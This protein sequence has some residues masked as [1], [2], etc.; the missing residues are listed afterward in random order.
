MTIFE[1]NL[2]T[3]HSVNKEIAANIEHAK[4]PEWAECIRAHNHKP[5]ILVHAQANRVPAY[6]MDNP[7]KRPREYIKDTQFFRENITV[8]IGMGCGYLLHE[9]LKKKDKQHMVLVVEPLHWFM[10]KAFEIYDYSKWILD[11]TLAIAMNEVGAS[12]SIYQIDSAQVVEQYNIFTEPY[13]YLRPH[14]YDKV[15]H[16]VSDQL[17]SMLCNTGTVMNAGYEFARNDISN[18]PYL[19]R[20]RGISEVKEL[21]AGKPAVLVSTGPSLMKNIHRLIDIQDKV[22][23]VAVAQALRPLL[24][25]GI[26]P[27][28]ICTVDFGATN[29][30][31]FAGLMDCDIPLVVLNR[32][33]D[34]ILKEWEGPKFVVATPQPGFEESAVNILSGKGFCEQGGSVSHLALSFAVYLGCSQ[35]TLIGQDLAYEGNLSHTPLADASGKVAISEAGIAWTVDDPGSHLKK[36]ETS[37]DMGAIKWVPGYFGDMVPTNYG[38]A[39]FI[40]AFENMV[41]CYNR[42]FFNSTEGGAS[43]KGFEN[44]TL[45]NY[46]SQFAQRKIDKSKIAKMHGF[47]ADA[48][49]L[50]DQVTPKL[51]K[52]IAV[53]NEISWNASKGLRA[54]VRVEKSK[55]EVT[56]KAAF[57][58]N[59][60]Y[61]KTAHDY[62]K[63]S[64][65]MGIAIY[66]ESRLIS[67]HALRAKGK[68]SHLLQNEKDRKIRIDRNKLILKAAIKAARQLRTLYLECLG[69]L[70]KYQAT[71]DESILTAK[72][73][74]KADL[75]KCEEYFAK[76]N[77][78]WPLLVADRYDFKDNAAAEEVYN[79]AV[80]MKH[81]SIRKAEAIED[82]S[83]L[84]EYLELLEEGHKVGREGK[85]DQALKIL[86]AAK[87]KKPERPEARWGYATTLHH[88]GKYKKAVAEY[89]SIVT[90]FP[91][92]LTFLFEYGQV[93]LKSDPDKG[94]KVITSVMAKT[95]DYD[96]FFW[97]IAEIYRTKKDYLLA[98]QAYQEYKKVYPAD[99]RALTVLLECY[100]AIKDDKGVASISRELTKLT[101]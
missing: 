93:L 75:S 40:T 71:R 9:T 11:G 66:H 87:K 69:K 56:M 38:L 76:G 78:A 52:D 95:H 8:I 80:G 45:K 99:P 100:K 24:A 28:F 32:S 19:I 92:K 60:K 67:G 64:A 96:Y 27:D 3:I 13:I 88:I 83:D 63:K 36:D 54:A 26:K 16:T 53:L 59:E 30:E 43:I 58:E 4:K 15:L 97:H 85:Y 82:Q 31:H 57:V 94:M 62:A 41:K 48:D 17:N 2:Q 22:I 55:D 7:E 89:E 81:E 21:Y 49:E 86:L 79:R 12:V 50:I 72:S 25:Y 39:S 18:L 34:R 65:L 1:K 46:L 10:K 61:S 33:Y 90:D 84:L 6:D 37:Y 68:V 73:I 74:D 5:N 20:H 47:A 42:K 101:Q 14:E 23:I 98:I 77:W 51:R 29:Y 44:R 70:E 35:I 91:D